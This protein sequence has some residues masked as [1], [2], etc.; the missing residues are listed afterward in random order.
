MKSSHHDSSR[1]SEESKTECGDAIAAV[2]NL[3]VSH[4]EIMRRG[5]CHG[6][7]S[8][9]PIVCLITAVRALT[10]VR[11]KILSSSELHPCGHELLPHIQQGLNALV[12]AVRVV[13][14]NDA[15][16]PENPS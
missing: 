1:A 12:Q 13:E 4:P 7:G 14:S 3:G 10:Q 11:A 5:M 6:S 16:P 9:D 8:S 2:T 15:V